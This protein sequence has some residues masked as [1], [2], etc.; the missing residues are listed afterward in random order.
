MA[1]LSMYARAI[2]IRLVTLILVI[3]VTAG[4]AWRVHLATV[5]RLRARLL[6]SAPDA[7]VK[8]PDLVK[9]A[10]TEAQPLYAQHCAACH[11]ER[12]Q[13]NTALGA[14]NLSDSIWL[15]GSGTVFDI[16]RTLLYGIRS[17][18]PKA[19]NVSDMPPFGLTGKLRPGQIREIVA[20]LLQLS[21]RPH[22]GQAALAGRE[23]FFDEANCTDC[24]G[25]DGK[26]NNDYGAPD[27]T[28]NVWNSGSDPEAI[29]KSIYFGRHRVMPGWIGTLTLEQIRA[30]SVYI[31]VVSHSS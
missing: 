16:E 17:E 28:A 26:G 12:L 8:E 15:Y 4:A 13:G 27:L 2:P 7:L 1:A 20:Y 30:L 11:G 5:E 14:P 19:H 31:Y 10:V 21:G 3:L 6:Q 18:M 25:A 22:D 29:Y 24:H 9:T 23:L